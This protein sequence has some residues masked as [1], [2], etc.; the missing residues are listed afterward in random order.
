MNTLTT[1]KITVIPMIRVT[2]SV[3]QKLE[4]LATADRRTLTDYCRK[5]L[6]EAAQK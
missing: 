4:K 2:E 1:K 5:L 3:R 6:I